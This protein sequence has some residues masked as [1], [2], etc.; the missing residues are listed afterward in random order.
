M[1]RFTADGIVVDGVEYRVDAIVF[2]TG[3]ELGAD[4]ATRAGVD[5]RGRGGITLAD[6]WADGLRTLHGWVS[7]GFPN[8]FHLGHRG[9]TP[10]R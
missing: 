3:F 6:Y 1:D 8:L 9:R 5:I 7:R 10:C 2:A 4:P